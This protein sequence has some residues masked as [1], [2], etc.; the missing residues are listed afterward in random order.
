MILFVRHGQT[1][2]NKHHKFQ[3]RL[4]TS[5]NEE[6]IK[7]AQQLATTLKDV[8]FDV[9]Y[10]S[11][12]TR[13]KHTAQIINQYH[14]VELIENEQITEIEL[15]D[16][17][18]APRNLELLSDLNF[19]N[20]AQKHNA[21][22][23]A[24]FYNRCVEFYNKIKDQK[25]NILIVAHSGVAQQLKRYLNLNLDEVMNNCDVITLKF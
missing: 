25:K 23:F 16:L 12:L 17:T 15:G 22:C 9:I 7:Q 1:D 19:K 2:Y 24:E 18:G 6:G 5:L 14:N 11:P 21:E 3:G 4:N 13:A 10:T 8:K 20:L